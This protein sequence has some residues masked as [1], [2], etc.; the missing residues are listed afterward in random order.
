[1]SRRGFTLIE[2]LVVIAI[3]GILAAILLPALA[4][5]RESARRASCAN[6]LKQLG[7]VYKM[8]SN[9]SLGA[10]FPRIQLCPGFTAL[11]VGPY[12][13]SVYP[14]YLTDPSIL[15]CPSDSGAS[16]DDLYV[17]AD[18]QAD[19]PGS[20]IGDCIFSFQEGWKKV[21]TSYVYLGW[22][23]DQL[24]DGPEHPAMSV[25]DVMPLLQMAG[26]DPD[27]MPAD[28][29]VPAQATQ[30]LISVGLPA[31]AQGNVAPADEDIVF[32][33]AAHQHY[34]NGGGPVVYRLCEGIERML[35]RD[36]NNP[37]ATAMSQSDIW[38]QCDVLST[39]VD[40]FNHVPGGC[41]VLYMDGHVEFI[42]FKA[43]A[44]ISMR[45]AILVSA[46]AD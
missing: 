38:I 14:E 44:P 2:L 18:T 24:G 46:L 9:E 32:T 45:F 17:Q 27:N 20:Q 43:A 21:G 30:G 28:G 22:V 1:M 41:N 37:G 36:V 23:L 26:A 34:G 6:N 5:A 40:M 12:V 39:Q 29:E 19:Y 31:F 42:K 8:Y 25:S 3:I 16:V 33:E 10:R 4:R 11:G 13:P 7:L 15:I 35:V